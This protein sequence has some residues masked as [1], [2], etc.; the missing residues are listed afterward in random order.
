MSLS[1]INKA[2]ASH[3][4]ELRAKNVALYHLSGHIDSPVPTYS[5]DFYAC[6]RASSISG[7]KRAFAK[8]MR[9]ELYHPDMPNSHVI[10]YSVVQP[11]E[12]S[13]VFAMRRFMTPVKRVRKRR[14]DS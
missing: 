12:G 2:V 7:A 10:T 6:V 1:A 4:K 3:V 5:G 13:F 11:V 14:T 9:E 8:E